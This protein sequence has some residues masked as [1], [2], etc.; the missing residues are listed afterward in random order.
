M[1][2]WTLVLLWTWSF[3]TGRGQTAPYR[4]VT[5]TANCCLL[6]SS[7]VSLS[8]HLS[9]CLLTCVLIVSSESV[10]CVPGQ[11]CLLPCSADKE[12][13]KIILWTRPGTPEDKKGLVVISSVTSITR[14]FSKGNISLQLS[15]VKV[16]D[17]GRFMCRTQTSSGTITDKNIHLHSSLSLKLRPPHHFT[18]NIS[19]EHSWKSATYSFNCESRQAHEKLVEQHSS[20]PVSALQKRTI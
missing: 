6:V 3:A 13:V 8:P 4:L 11:K 5:V 19:T 7:F 18:C 1:E 17:D 12:N 9:P 15:P 10:S 20:A 14:E 2:L 16:S